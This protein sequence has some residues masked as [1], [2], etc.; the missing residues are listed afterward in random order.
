MNHQGRRSRNLFD[1]ESADPFKLSRSKLE[2]FL[3]C[4]LCFYLDR[5]IGVMQPQSAPYSLNNAVDYLLKREFDAYRGRDEQ[6]PI[7]AA[8]RIPATLYKSPHL[9][10][11][12]SMLKGIQSLHRESNFLVFGALD[13]VWADTAGKLIVV[14]YKS[15][16][17]EKEITLEGS[18][19]LSYKRQ[20]E[21]YQWLLRRSGYDVSDTSY[22]V[23]VNASKARESFDG[24][25]E[26]SMS[27]LPYD[28]DASWVDDALVEARH[29]LV[30]PTCPPPARDCPWCIYRKSAQEFPVSED[31]VQEQLF[32][33]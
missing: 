7:L 14:D 5:R 15:T 4:P 27:I 17:T 2:L 21:I 25:L 16:S 28:G 11:W 20:V 30:R 3:K 19:K 23:Y 32:T 26:F 8:H 12:R 9:E 29:C 33:L 1:S 18:W 13:D 24:R 22:F 31:T 6:H 10:E